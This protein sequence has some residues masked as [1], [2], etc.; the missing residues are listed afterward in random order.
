MKRLLLLALSPILLACSDE[1][2]ISVMC[3]ADPKMCTDIP[4]DSWCKRE[5]KAVLLANHYLNISTSD[6]DKYKLLR[7]YEEYRDCMALA[8]QIEHIKLKHKKTQRVNNLAKVKQRIETLSLETKNS[9]D[10]H[11]LHFH[12][13][14]YLDENSLAKFL[15][16]EG[17]G[18]LETPELQHKLATYYI[19]RDLDKTLNLLFHAL[20]LYENGDEINPEI[21]KSI[22]SIF[23]DKKEYKQAYIWYQIIYLF[24]PQDKDVSAE[25]ITAYGQQFQLDYQFLNKVADATLGKIMEG[26]FKAPKH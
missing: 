17:S 6:Y 16:L 11:L 15:E 4:A 19:K 18:A 1:P 5:R 7:G 13:S 21:F 10:P 9:S 23:A 8:S 26:T 25:S 2:S 20:E 3:D 12:W 14:R 22:S 24:D